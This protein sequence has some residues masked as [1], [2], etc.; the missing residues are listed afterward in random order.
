MKNNTFSCCY[1]FEIKGKNIDS[2]T[3][4]GITTAIYSVGNLDSSFPRGADDFVTINSANL[5]IEMIGDGGNLSGR[6]TGIVYNIDW[7]RSP[8][9]G[10]A[11]DELITGDASI[12]SIESNIDSS[13]IAYCNVCC[14]G[15]DGDVR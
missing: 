11:G 1:A 14:T 2:L 13:G 12:I 10:I 5:G 3:L 7:S 6:I 15:R 4:S 9:V 8:G